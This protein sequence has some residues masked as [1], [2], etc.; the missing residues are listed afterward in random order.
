[1]SI[2]CQSKYYSL[3]TNIMSNRIKVAH[4]E[5]CLYVYL[6]QYALEQCYIGCFTVLTVYVQY[7]WIRVRL[8]EPQQQDVDAIVSK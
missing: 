6:V 5:G 8:S 4:N 2:W 7:E 3:F 1:M